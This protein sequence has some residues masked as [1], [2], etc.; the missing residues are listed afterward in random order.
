MCASSIDTR[1][2]RM[3]VFSY[4]SSAGAVATTLV[5][6]YPALNIDD[7]IL[8]GIPIWFVI[9]YCCYKA[10]RHLYVRNVETN[11][12]S[13]CTIRYTV[14]LWCSVVLMVVTILSSVLYV[15]ISIGKLVLVTFGSVVWSTCVVSVSVISAIRTIEAS[16]PRYIG[17][18]LLFATTA[19]GALLIPVLFFRLMV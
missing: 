16:Y 9:G 18:G 19:Y 5:V 2:M 13:M 14:I 4:M 11:R 1:V 7:A 3:A 15:N 10:F 12:E 17:W 8:M 6:L